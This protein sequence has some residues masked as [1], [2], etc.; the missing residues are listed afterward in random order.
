MNT[1]WPLFLLFLS[2]AGGDST[3]APAAPYGH[4]EGAVDRE[5]SIQRVSV[6]FSGARGAVRATYDIPEMGYA[7]V[8]CPRIAW[9]GDTLWLSL[10]YGAFGC[11]VDSASGDITGISERWNPRIRLHLKP[12]EPPAGDFHEIELAFHNGKV[13]L[14]GSLLVPA[15]KPLSWVVM[16]HG[17][18]AQDRDTPYYRSLG[19][20]LARRGIGVLI[21]DK[22][23]CGRSS[24][25]WTDASFEDLA[26]DAV[27]G[28]RALRARPELAVARAGFLG[29]SQ[30]GWIAPIAA[31]RAREC[32]FVVLNVGPAVSVAEQDL[33]RVRYSMA[34]DAIDPAVRDSAVA[35]TKT[36]FDYVRFPTDA[37][38][39]A[40]ERFAHAVRGRPWAE[41]VN[42][43]AG[44]GDAD[45]KWWGDHAYDPA[46]SLRTMK[47]PVLALFGEKDVLV[48]PA[49][50]RPR[51]EAL[52]AGA[53]VRH[54]I[55]VIAGTGHD[56]LTDQ[57]L[58]GDRWDWP[59]V[60]WHWRR[61][62]PEFVRAIVAFVNGR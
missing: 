51:M 22:R 14:Y 9:S 5:G 38:W 29:T 46:T 33:D 61:Q 23:G 36:Y 3:A 41:Y 24:G 25:S 52:L 56:M 27:A 42:L 17:S 31:H 2:W 58:N 1:R 43:P 19:T 15:V 45:L 34:H 62:P 10:A 12:A 21:Y 13:T 26:G 44:R 47:C 35:Y 40:L 59:Q 16:I 50:N 57:W 11:R 30:G 20:L 7:S 8:P 53:G 28:L 6:D 39:V 37:G 55:V 60:Y 54:R 18:G 32:A 49:D 48:P 4:Y